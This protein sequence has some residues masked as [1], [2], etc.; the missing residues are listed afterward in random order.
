MIL[1]LCNDEESLIEF[2]NTMIK[3]TLGNIEIFSKL[4]DDTF[5]NYETVIPKENDKKL[6]INKNEL[7]NALRRAS[8]FAD[9]VTK[10]VRLEIKNNTVIIRAD[11]PEIGAEGEESIEANFIG[12]S[13]D[14][15]FNAEPF[16]VA[17]NVSYLLDCLVQMETPEVIF[18]F[19][20]PA[21]ASIIRPTEQLPN[22]DIMELIMPV[23]VS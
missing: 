10:R 9:V 11:N 3:V 19:N 15:D 21:K 8:I 4:I 18:S 13:G 12:E 23:R 6:E 1:K 7:A 17:F 2:D 5:P 22:E 16:I 20:T 14:T